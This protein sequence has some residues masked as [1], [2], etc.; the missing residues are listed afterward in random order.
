AARG[1]RRSARPRATRRSLHGTARSPRSGRA[2]AARWRARTTS[3]TYRGFPA[4]P[5]ARPPS[6]RPPSSRSGST[7]PSATSNLAAATTPSCRCPT[8]SSRLLQVLANQFDVAV[9]R[10]NLALAVLGLLV[11]HAQPDLG[12]EQGIVFER[13]R[14]LL[15]HRPALKAQRAARGLG[16]SLPVT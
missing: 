8:S 11:P 14:F 13:P 12:L 16:E 3:S 5:Q 4:A 2:G 10:R 15:A 9:E 7:L 6:A 1:S